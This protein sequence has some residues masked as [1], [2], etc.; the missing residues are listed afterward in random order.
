MKKCIGCG[1]M[2]ALSEYYKMAHMADGHVNRCKEC[3][4]EMVRA[5]YR[6]TIEARTAYERERWQR[7]ERRADAARYQN[8][9]RKKYPEKDRA[10]NLVTKAMKAGSLRRQPCEKCGTKRA[11]AHHDDYSKPLQ[12][13]WL[14]YKHHLAE[15]G[16]EKR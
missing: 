2:K 12:V 8:K 4:K 15:H 11:Q 10:R 3:T 14:C 6:K 13:R 5:N 1:E 9:R 7:P 16:K